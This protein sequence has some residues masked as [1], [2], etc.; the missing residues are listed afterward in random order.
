[1]TADWFHEE[2]EDW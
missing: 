2:K 1:V